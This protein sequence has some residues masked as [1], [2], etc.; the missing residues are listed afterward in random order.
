LYATAFAAAAGMNLGFYNNAAR[1]RVEQILRRTN[2]F[3]A[4]LRH[5]AARHCDAILLQNCF[6]LILVNF[7]SAFPN[8]AGHLAAKTFR[9]Q[10]RNSI[11]RSRI[12]KA[13]SLVF[14]R[15]AL[16]PSW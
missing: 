3:V 5:P 16:C 12:G 4:A 10:T 7:H 13:D 1:A 8:Q 11:E 6:C 9:Q 2:S 15:V 14:L